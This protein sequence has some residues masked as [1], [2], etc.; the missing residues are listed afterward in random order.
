[1]NYKIRKKIIALSTASLLL[2]S[3]AGC[4]NADAYLKEELADSTA[5]NASATNIT[6]ANASAANTSSSTNLFDISVT[7]LNASDMFTER[8]KEIG[9]DDN[10][11][12]SITLS[13]NA[14]ASS[15]NNVSIND[16]IVTISDEGTYIL[17]GTL[18][19]GMIIIDADNTDKIQLVLNNAEINCNSS[20]AIYIKKADK[21]F[22]TLASGSVN[23]LSTNGEFSA[24]DDSN[25]D[26]VIFSKSDLTLNGNGSLTV[27]SASGHGIVS[28]DDLKIT[29]G[30]YDITAASSALSGKDSVRIADGTISLHAEKDGIHSENS[31]D[32]NKGFIYIAGG[33]FSID[34]GSDGLDASST[35]QIDGGSFS[36]YAEDDAFH[37]ETDLIIN[38]GN[39]IIEK[40]YEGLEGKTVTVN[41]G[42]ISLYATDD[43]VN[44]AG[45]SQSE[46]EFM[47]PSG[48]GNPNRN[49]SS[50]N[51]TPPDG[52]ALPDGSTPPNGFSPNGG[53]PFATD[54]ECSIVINGGILH[55]NADGDGIDSNGSF[56]VTGGEVYVSGPTNNS[57]SALDYDGN[58]LITG[59]IVIAA[60]PSQMAQNFGENSSQGSMLVT[61]SSQISAGE[62]ITLIDASGKELLTYT[63]EKACNSVVISCPDIVQGETYTVT[64]GSQSYTIEMDSLIYG[65]GG[66]GF[67]GGRHGFGGG[68][69]DFDGN[70]SGFDGNPPQFDNNGGDMENRQMPDGTPPQPDDDNRN[71]HSV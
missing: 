4:A 24:I 27:K 3:L 15:G 62:T 17:S 23:T 65:N 13:D 29:S 61:L 59:G 50:D 5:S 66:F 12:V 35:L 68:R 25:I 63:P 37:S 69:S 70:R 31:E 56:A 34:C 38:D 28:K 48:A 58:A 44:A 6:A 60:G 7:Y 45:S 47:I 43:G 1:M 32:A 54:N 39:V 36:L 9:Y 18:S 33:N 53:S 67:G 55:I 64:A 30:T 19:N 21:V 22:L 20:A 41:G 10:T 71:H 57:N 40:C 52:F 42:N 2:F 51:A 16:N 11:A 8:D 26:G 14:S 49:T 46:F